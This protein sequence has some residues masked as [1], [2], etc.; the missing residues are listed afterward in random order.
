MQV[1]YRNCCRRLV[2]LEFLLFGKA[3]VPSQPDKRGFIVLY[4]AY[5]W[6]SF[7]KTFVIKLI[8]VRYT[9]R[10]NLA[11]RCH[12][13]RSGNKERKQRIKRK[14]L[15]RVNL[16]LFC[17]DCFHAS[18]IAYLFSR[19]PVPVMFLRTQLYWFVCI[20]LEFWDFEIDFK[21][22]ICYFGSS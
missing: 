17:L 4:M 12:S 13:Q 11:S 18:I 10:R 2:Y 20:V 21:V 16:L 5:F 1:L 6:N 14:L 15:F 3:L 7:H 8:V 19:P 9:T 22:N